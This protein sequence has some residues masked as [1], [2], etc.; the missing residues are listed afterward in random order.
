M[1]LRDFLKEAITDPITKGASSTRILAF[2]FGITGC[3]TAFLCD[4]AIVAALV[5]GG[6]VALLTRAKSD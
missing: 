3:I 2:M 1:N 6:S 5:G 4:A